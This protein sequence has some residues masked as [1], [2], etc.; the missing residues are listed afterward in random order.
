[1]RQLI[2]RKHD[3]AAGLTDLPLSKV[4]QY[5]EAWADSYE[6]PELK[7]SEQPLKGT[8]VY[9]FGDLLE[10]ELTKRLQA[11]FFRYLPGLKSGCRSC[12]R[13]QS[14]LNRMGAN[15]VNRKR[16][17]IID[18]IVANASDIHTLIPA[19]LTAKLVDRDWF[20][21]EVSTCIDAA[22]AQIPQ[23]K[24]KTGRRRAGR[25]KNR[26]MRPLAGSPVM[27]T[28]PVPFTGDPQLH[29]MFHVW[30]HGEGWK[31]HIED[32]QP[33]LHRFSTLKL[34]I[35]TDNSTYNAEYVKE[36]FGPRWEVFEVDNVPG[37]H[38]LREVATYQQMLP[39]LPD[40]ANDVTFC[41]HG[42]GAQDHTAKSD[43]IRWWIDAMY[44][45]V[46]YNIDGVIRELQNGAAV[47]GS[48]RRHGAH[49]G[50]RHRWHYSGTYYAFRNCI[51][52]NQGVPTYRQRYW[53]TES[54]PGDHF[55]LK[56]SACVFGDDAGD[57]YK[58]EQQPRDELKQWKAKHE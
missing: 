52:F 5:R 28:S 46:Y 9:K 57:L 26:T 27:P 6:L 14:Q 16:S 23:T 8:Q 12:K 44:S 38:G 48:F 25:I 30:P 33:Q 4:L 50:V 18:G 54:W 34:G 36:R 49:L 1:M 20:R 53:G 24:T 42:K 58:P 45:T 39:T 47:V 19:S 31:R 29:L 37:K 40:G 15:A 22:L 55:P 32:L 11:S 56:S 51:A 17:D 41:L 43:A 3:I 10:A 2:G 21:S 13:M 35:A 7:V